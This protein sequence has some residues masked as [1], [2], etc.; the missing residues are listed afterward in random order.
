MSTKDV[1]DSQLLSLF[2]S[3]FFRTFFQMAL[4]ST[5]VSL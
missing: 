3:T 4:L 5:P 1:A 2:K